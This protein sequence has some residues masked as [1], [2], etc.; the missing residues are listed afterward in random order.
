MLSIL[1]SEGA[2]CYQYWP[3]RGQGAINIGQFDELE[4]NFIISVLPVVSL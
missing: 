1:A 4:R 2:R 3:V